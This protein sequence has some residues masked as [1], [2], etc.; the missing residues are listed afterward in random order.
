[1]GTEIF[2]IDASWAEKLEENEGLK[3][4]VANCRTAATQSVIDILIF[5]FN[6][7]SVKSIHLFDQ[8]KTLVELHEPKA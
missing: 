8:M 3:D 6:T 1:M 5:I 7:M 4:S 2:K